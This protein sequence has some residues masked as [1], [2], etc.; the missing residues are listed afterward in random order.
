MVRKKCRIY[1]STIDDYSY[2]TRNTLIHNTQIGKYCSISE[3][4]AI[5]SILHPLDMVSTSPVF[6]EGRNYFHKHFAHF[7]HDGCRRTVIG[8]DIWIGMKCLIKDGIT[9]G[10]GAVIAMGVG[11]NKRRRPL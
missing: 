8:N 11:C 3:D 7:K 2:V 4:C 10:D 6:L 5:G 9:I 1:N